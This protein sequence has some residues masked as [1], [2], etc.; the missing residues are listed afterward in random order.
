MK[1]EISG[2]GIM[3]CDY[4]SSRFFIIFYSKP[5]IFRRYSIP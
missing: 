4:L 5:K 1:N 3:F 2:N